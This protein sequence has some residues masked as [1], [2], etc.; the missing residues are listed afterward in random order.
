MNK[1]ITRV[2]I[3][4]T[5]VLGAGWLGLWFLGDSRQIKIEN[6]NKNNPAASQSGIDDGSFSEFGGKTPRET[7]DLLIA[8][9]EKNNLTLAAKYFSSELRDQESLELKKLYDAKLLGDLINALKGIKEGKETDSSHFGFPVL[10]ETGEVV[11]IIQLEKNISG[12][13]K[14]SSL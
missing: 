1:S 6:Q 9:L 7:L 13:W 12:F 11:A 8:A 5:L 10:D 14:I 4:L 3:V 2:I